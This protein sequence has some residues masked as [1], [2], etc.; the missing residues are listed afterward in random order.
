MVDKVNMI[1]VKTGSKNIKVNVDDEKGVNMTTFSALGQDEHF[2]VGLKTVIDEDRIRTVTITGTGTGNS[3]D[4]KVGFDGSDDGMLICENAANVK[5]ETSDDSGLT[6]V[7]LN[8]DKKLVEVNEGE[9]LSLNTVLTPDT[10][11]A[12]LS[13]ISSDKEAAA[14]SDKGEVTGLKPGKSVIEVTAT[15][16]YTGNVYKDSCTVIVRSKRYLAVKQKADLKE[17]GLFKEE[18]KK[19]EYDKKLMSVNKKGL[20]KAKKPGTVTLTGLTESGE[21]GESAEIVIEA[22]KFT[23][24]AKKLT[25]SDIGEGMTIELSELL[26]PGTNIL[27][28]SFESSKENIAAFETDDDKKT[29][30]LTVKPVK[31]STKITAYFGEGKNA[32]KL[33]YKVKVKK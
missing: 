23:E 22:P 25:L 26:D 5:I 30:K 3:N 24:K 18:Y 8:K 31:G 13:Y 32:A 2:E 28:D 12:K 14:V 9:K 27:P 10:T 4:I 33:I 11:I 21:K 6:G 19:Y 29:G 1:D 20:I 15:D 16:I 17:L 7:S